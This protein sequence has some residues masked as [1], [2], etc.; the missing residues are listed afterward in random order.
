MKNNLLLALALSVICL[1][2]LIAQTSTSMRASVARSFQSDFAGAT[3]VKVQSVPKRI[4]LIR[5]NL[6]E[7]SWLAYYDVDGN[8]LTSGRRIKADERLP[9]IVQESLDG[10]RE[11]Y[12]RKFGTIAVGSPY[13]MTKGKATVYYVPMQN[14]Q[15][16]MLVSIDGF[17]ESLV[18]N[19][20]ITKPT[21]EPDKSVLAK[22]N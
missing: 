1:H 17:G 5:F 12:E 14:A 20:R 19:K 21:I 9:L 8:L 3:D 16:D 11:K 18:Y 4:T 15:I 7:G 6:N 13:E 22:K 10:I 2:N